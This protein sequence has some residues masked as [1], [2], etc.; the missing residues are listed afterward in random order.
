MYL[1]R[2]KDCLCNFFE[3][4]VQIS[5]LFSACLPWW[6]LWAFL[7][8]NISWQNSQIIP[9]FILLLLDFLGIAALY[10]LGLFLGFGAL[11]K[12]GPPSLWWFS[13]CRLNLITIEYTFGH[14]SHL[15]KALLL[16]SAVVPLRETSIV[17][18]SVLHCSSTWIVCRQHKQP[19]FTF[20][21]FH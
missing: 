20:I 7:S 11:V 9:S 10:L 13:L 14:L 19:T 3:H 18:Q 5:V 6:R 1:E 2:F 8:W 4:K 17:Q 15:N 12:S 16:F 21:T